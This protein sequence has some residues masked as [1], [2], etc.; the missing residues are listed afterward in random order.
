MKFLSGIIVGTLCF[1]ATCFGQPRLPFGDPSD[2]G[3]NTEPEAQA[4]ESESSLDEDVRLHSLEM[5]RR[6]L[7]DVR[8]LPPVLIGAADLELFSPVLPSGLKRLI[9]EQLIQIPVGDNIP[10]ATLSFHVAENWKPFSAGKSDLLQ[11]TSDG[12]TSSAYVDRGFLFGNSVDIQ[13]EAE[14]KRIATK[15]L[16]N[17][18][19]VFWSSGSFAADLSF[20]F[21]EA[22]REFR[23]MGGKMVRIYPRKIDSGHKSEQL[24]RELIYFTDPEQVRG[25]AWLTLRFIGT[26]EDRVLVYSNVLDAERQLTASNRSDPLPGDI[27][28]PDDLLGW[29]GAVTTASA[30]LSAVENLLLPV[31]LFPPSAEQVENSCT[32]ATTKT[33]QLHLALKTVTTDGK[34]TRGQPAASPF[35]FSHNI[36]FAPR[37]AWRLQ[38]GRGDPYSLYARQVV[39]LEYNSMLPVV[40]EVYDQ[41]DRLVKVILVAYGEV[42]TQT[43]TLP[44]PV[45]EL[46]YD[47]QQKRAAVIQF[48]SVTIC[49]EGLSQFPDESLFPGKFSALV[50]EQLLPT[51]KPAADAPEKGPAPEA[52]IK[53]QNDYLDHD[54]DPSGESYR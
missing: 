39:Y 4:T 35:S 43:G 33:E 15:L 17:S 18:H 54:Y 11:D 42:Q 5:I 40:K 38:L 47:V 24:F 53:K 28:S 32:R 10:A 9:S 34:K 52:P 20:R 25:Y 46:V 3:R 41:E 45:V 13:A 12:L 49:P 2:T 37:K 8:Q 29:S 44:L 16:W 6:Q 48:D 19:S 21:Y 26:D 7:P 36:V 51:N 31:P 30:T 1:A 22:E 27:V 14:D 50:K 23:T